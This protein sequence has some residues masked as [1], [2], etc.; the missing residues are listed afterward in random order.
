MSDFREE[1]NRSIHIV[2]SGSLMEDQLIN[3]HTFYE[4]KKGAETSAVPA[5]LMLCSAAAPEISSPLELTLSPVSCGI[6]LCSLSGCARISMDNTS[7]LLSEGRAAFL[8]CQTR[9]SIR[10]LTLP[11]KYI[12]LF[13][14]GTLL[15]W[16]EQS[17]GGMCTMSADN[18]VLFRSRFLRLMGTPAVLSAQDIYEVSRGLT[19]ILYD[20]CRPSGNNTDG[21]FSPAGQKNSAG[22][23]SSTGQKNPVLLK[24]P[25]RLK[26]SA[27]LKN[28]AILKNSAGLEN[29]ARLKTPSVLPSYLV[30][31]KGWYDN[32]YAVSCS[33]QSFEEKTGISRYRLCREFSA[34]YHQT[35]IRYLEQVRMEKACILLRETSLNIHEVAADVGYE[36]VT[37]FIRLFRNETGMTPGQYRKQFR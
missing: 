11:W 33:L 23:K 15:P 28:P 14:R 17:A 26:N 35:P 21:S 6:L 20:L 31:M 34:A 12:V 25:A 9:I 2:R 27:G 3:L 5:P 32:H 19:D 8:P 22:L 4:Q 36:N 18:S 30:Y 10:A 29:S 13:C 37:H 7:L 16:F 1:L 24:N